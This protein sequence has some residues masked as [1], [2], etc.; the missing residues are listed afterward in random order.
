MS[1]TSLLFIFF[2]NYGYLLFRFFPV[3][4]GGRRAAAAAA[5]GVRR[6]FLLRFAQQPPKETAAQQLNNKINEIEE[7]EPTEG[8][9]EP[10]IDPLPP[11][12]EY[13]AEDYLVVPNSRRYCEGSSILK[14]TSAASNFAAEED[15]PNRVRQPKALLCAGNPTDWAREE[16]VATF[17]RKGLAAVQ[18]NPKI[19]KK[20][21][22]KKGNGSVTQDD[23]FDSVPRGTLV[24]AELKELN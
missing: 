20:R 21:K 11:A 5:P 19:R 24:V 9:G 6:S 8:P 14:A 1:P 22:E 3:A 13:P 4:A 16:G 15:P 17:L 23:L 12:Y 2:V 7:T 10:W 18:I